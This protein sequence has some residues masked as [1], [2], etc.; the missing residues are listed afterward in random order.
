M[1]LI[2]SPFPCCLR[3]A[4]L[5]ISCRSAGVV[6]RVATQSRR[7]TAQHTGKSALCHVRCASRGGFSYVVI[8]SEGRGCTMYDIFVVFQTIRIDCYERLST[9]L[10][11]TESNACLYRTSELLD[12]GIAWI[13]GS[14]P[15]SADPHV[16]VIL[17]YGSLSASHSSLRPYANTCS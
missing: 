13:V 5:F 8:R 14:L 7:N 2:Y 4:E 15:R 9:K 1:S 10:L 3:L 6:Q 17:A 12:R 11:S 16:T